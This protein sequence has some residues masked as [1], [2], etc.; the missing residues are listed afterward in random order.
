MRQRY[1]G[2]GSESFPDT[3]VARPSCT[4]VYVEANSHAE[5]F[6]TTRLVASRFSAQQSVSYPRAMNVNYLA[7]TP[8]FDIISLV[9]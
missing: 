9:V 1:P 3:N 5:T 4:E 6:N 8:D 2:N 7:L